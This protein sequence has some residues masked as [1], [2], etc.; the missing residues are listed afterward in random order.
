M[1][2]NGTGTFFC[3][4]MQNA[5]CTQ[6]N[7]ICHGQKRINY[8]WNGST[9]RWNKV[10]ATC[11]EGGLVLFISNLPVGFLLQSEYDGTIDTA[12]TSAITNHAGE[13]GRT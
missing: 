4:A 2:V 1:I 10:E 5:S 13:K 12:I 7:T 3:I 9:R 8:F 6:H 11:L